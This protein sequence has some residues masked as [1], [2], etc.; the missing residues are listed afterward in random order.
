MAVRHVARARLLLG[1]QIFPAKVAVLFHDLRAAL[2][3]S[4]SINALWQDLL[5]VRTLVVQLF[6][7][8]LASRSSLI[9]T[10]AYL[11]ILQIYSADVIV[12]VFDWGPLI[13]LLSQNSVLLLRVTVQTIWSIICGLVLLTLML[14][15]PVT[16]ADYCSFFW[17]ISL[18]IVASLVIHDF[19]AA[20]NNYLATNRIH[21]ILWLSFAVTAILSNFGEKGNDSSGWLV[22]RLAHDGFPD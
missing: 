10:K 7:K 18:I 11:I 15:E 1:I 22:T 21:I 6:Q 9:Q 3:C 5:P 2:T 16:P 8:G 4:L 14:D 13:I 17:Q 12:D 19:M 20:I